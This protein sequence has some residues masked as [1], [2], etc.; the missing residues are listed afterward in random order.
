MA[1]FSPFLLSALAFGLL[2]CQASGYTCAYKNEKISGN[3]ATEVD[4]VV[5][6]VLPDNKSIV[7]DRRLDSCFSLWSI[8]PGNDDIFVSKQGCWKFE[9]G[10]H[11]CNQDECNSSAP[12]IDSMQRAHNVTSQFCC[13]KGDY[14]NANMSS[15]YVPR[16]PLEPTPFGPKDIVTSPPKND[17][18]WTTIIVVMVCILCLCIAV[19]VI[20]LLFRMYRIRSL[21]S[22]MD[23]LG[24]LEAAP[25]EPS[26]DLDQLKVMNLVGQGRYCNVY[27]GILEEGEVA[28]KIF[29]GASRQCYLNEVEMYNLAHI[30][31]PNVLRFLGSS[32]RMGQDN[33]P[34][35]LLVAEYM[36]HGSLMNYLKENTYDWLGMCRLGQTA[37]AGLAHLHQSVDKGG[38]SRPAI[39]HRDINSRNVL[40]KSDLTCV[41]GDF[42]FAMKVFGS[43]V[44]REGDEDNSTIT[45]V[46]TVRYMSPEVLD[47]AVNL[48]DCESALK[49][50]DIYALGLV[51][52]EIGTRCSELYPGG[53][54]PPYKLPFSDELCPHPTFEDMQV[55]VSRG[56][57]RPAFPD[58]WKENNQ[59]LRSLKETIEDCW[60]H[61]SEARL[62][63][64]CVEE[65]IIEL[66]VL[67][68]KHH[69]VSPTIN[70]TSEGMTSATIT[71]T[72]GHPDHGPGTATTATVDSGAVTSHLSQPHSHADHAMTGE[73]PEGG[74]GM[75]CAPTGSVIEK[76]ERQRLLSPDTISTSLSAQSDLNLIDLSTIAPNV[77]PKNLH[78]SDENIERFTSDLKYGRPYSTPTESSEGYG[79]SEPNTSPSQPLVMHE[80]RP[81]LAGDQMTDNL[82]VWS[83][84]HNL[85]RPT[86][87]PVWGQMTVNEARAHTHPHHAL[88]DLGSESRPGKPDVNKQRQQARAAE[89]A[90]V[91]SPKQNLPPKEMEAS[92]S[93]N[94][95][96]NG[97]CSSLHST[98]SEGSANSCESDHSRRPNTL[99][100]P[101]NSHGSKKKLVAVYIPDSGPTTKVQTGIAKMDSVD[102]QCHPVKVA[103]N[104]THCKN[105]PGEPKVTCRARVQPS[106]TNP[107]NAR[108]LS[109]SVGDK[110]NDESDS[111]SL[112]NGNSKSKECGVNMDSK[113]TKRKVTPYRIAG[114]K[115]LS[116][117][118]G[119]SQGSVSSDDGS[120]ESDQASDS[121]EN[122]ANNN[123]GDQCNGTPLL[124]QNGHALQPGKHVTNGTTSAVNR[125]AVPTADNT[126]QLGG[127]NLQWGGPGKTGMEN[128]PRANY[129]VSCV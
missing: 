126:F 83:K 108:P 15:S 47:G 67:W 80:M 78:Y 24:M 112:L 63:A 34:E 19:P 82:G 42:G 107:S 22:K 55:H 10:Q 51:L 85:H 65:R 101:T 102:T 13:C 116:V 127:D 76:N 5:G 106:E 6:V 35:Y 31:H 3:V 44:V 93:D 70:P 27:R 90:P 74:F 87:L 109:W 105:K 33:W 28:V 97:S 125:H 121:S 117:Y 16:P 79:Y 20:F 48:R 25:P 18:S 122:S 69:T 8:R 84:R 59:A 26:V 60:D 9:A 1:G 129:Q 103:T 77:D 68:D 41:I 104:G 128:G 54:V 94:S 75:R 100:L 58:A 123:S 4:E 88:T 12:P 52:W 38:S 119:K 32:E 36:S 30:E 96:S 120:P 43:S 23:P 56:R 29:A 124:T 45:D 64:L 66:M 37:A 7:C 118:N 110:S 50:V 40:V 2:L 49:Q 73:G 91:T 99:P 72:R 11:D 98:L 71:H 89:Q 115:K 17:E 14:C 114:S 62:T 53:D 21:K 95:S 111:G 113:K 86:S 61:D 39:V 57:K 92:S 81:S 46:G